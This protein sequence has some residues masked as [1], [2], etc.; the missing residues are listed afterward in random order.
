MS[1]YFI[2]IYFCGIWT[3]SS[4]RKHLLITLLRLYKYPIQ[5]VP[6]LSQWYSGRGVVLTTHPH[7]VLRLKREYCASGSFWPV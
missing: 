5:M 7:L 1:L 3:F 2:V 6:G 4:S